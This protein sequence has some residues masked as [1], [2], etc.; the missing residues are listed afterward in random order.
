[1]SQKRL[2]ILTHSCCIIKLNIYIV[3]IKIIY[4][5]EDAL[6]TDRK[7][8]YEIY[9]QGSFSA[10]AKALFVSQPTLSIAV[11]RT[12]ER[13]G[14]T[15][16]DRSAASLRLT[17]EG[18]VYIR[19][20][21]Q[22]QLIE[23]QMHTELSDIA[24][25]KSGKLT[26][27]SENFATSFVLP[28]ILLPFFEAY[29]GIEVTLLETSADQLKEALLTEKA[30]LAVTHAF[31]DPAFRSVPLFEEEIL[32]AVPHGA[33]TDPALLAQA[34][35]PEQLHRSPLTAPPV[36]VTAFR[37]LP[38]LLL[39]NGNDMYRRSLAIFR[40]ADIRPAVKLYLDQMIT[41]Y[42]MVCAGVGA[43]F[44][45]DSLARN[46]VADGACLFFRI[47]SPEIRRKMTVVYKG[48][49]YISRAVNA[50]ITT[51]KEAFPAEE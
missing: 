6:V 51:A 35:T 48:R 49:H 42:N 1:M 41:S 47:D 21:E 19:A 40:A 27:C 5:K 36:E 7:Y 45:S 30:D 18:S 14:I 3:S 28:R 26:V 29:P 8:I 44:V 46:V 37:Q 31:D 12:E 2:L 15:I 43:A 25:L 13:L 4:S 9:R 20:V 10:A 22:M 33:V 38:F 39:K 24:E 17:Q 11:K 32:L 16:F 50:F 23:E 34:L